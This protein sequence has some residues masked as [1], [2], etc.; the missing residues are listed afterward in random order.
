VRTRDRSCRF[1]T[2]GQRVGWADADH[3][4]P[5]ACGGATD[6]TDLCCPCRSHHRL[7]T[8]ARGWRFQM[9]ADGVLTVTTPSGITRSTRPPGMRPPE[10]PDD[11]G[12]PENLPPPARPDDDPPP[13]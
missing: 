9:S 10:P 8:S 11:A 3:V 13:F 4:I 2:C 5:H 12:P 1:P 6:C 7:K